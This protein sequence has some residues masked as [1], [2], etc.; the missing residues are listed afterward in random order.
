MYK[1]I[2]D[3]KFYELLLDMHDLYLQRLGLLKMSFVQLVK[4]FNK[5]NAAEE[6]NDVENLGDEIC[7]VT[8][9]DDQEDEQVFLPKVLTLESGMKLIRTPK[10]RIICHTTPTM[11]SEEFIFLNVLLYHP[12]TS[13]DQIHL[14]IEDLTA[15]FQAKDQNPVRDGSGRSLTK[16]ETVRSRLFPNLNQDLW[17]NFFES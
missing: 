16:L 6:E 4:N 5:G 17:V 14:G 13:L 10:E 12:H 8:C 2:D 3:G 7:L 1:S 11:G 15:I 9:K